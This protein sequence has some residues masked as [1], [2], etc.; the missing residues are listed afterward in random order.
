[1]QLNQ[2]STYSLISQIENKNSSELQKVFSLIDIIS[3]IKNINKA[4]EFLKQNYQ[5][6]DTIKQFPLGANSFLEVV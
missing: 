1:M 5:I 4:K 2:Y 6:K 3:K